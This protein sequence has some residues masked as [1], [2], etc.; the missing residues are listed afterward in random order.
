MA[1]NQY[2]QSTMTGLTQYQDVP[3]SVHGRPMSISNTSYHQGRPSMGGMPPSSEYFSPYRTPGTP[4]NN[5]AGLRRPVSTVDFRG[6]PGAGPDDLAIVDAI[7]LCLSEV[8]L[9]SVTKKQGKHNPLK[10]FNEC[11]LIS[12][13]SSCSC[14]TAATNRTG[15]GETSV[16]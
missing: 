4:M 6:S 11:K 3:V 9:D 8:D 16:P 2:R 14:R 13:R 10:N 5:G 7:R 12:P 15:R 1:P